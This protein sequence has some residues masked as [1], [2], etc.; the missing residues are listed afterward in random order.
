MKLDTTNK[1]HYDIM[2]AL[3][4]PDGDSRF[5]NR[6]K[7]LFTARIRY[8]V[9]C[10]DSSAGVIRDMETKDDLI[11]QVL[12][13]APAKVPVWWLHYSGHARDALRALLRMSPKLSLRGFSR[14]EAERLLEAIDEIN[15][16]LYSPSPG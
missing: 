15:A 2:C 10:A 9:G 12:N 16:A 11:Q 7:T 3:R 14:D 1:N 4:G 6:C 13:S 8:W 5:M